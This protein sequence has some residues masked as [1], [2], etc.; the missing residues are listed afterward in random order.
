VICCSS[1]ADP[2]ARFAECGWDQMAP[3]MM[4]TISLF[5]F[6][7]HSKMSPKNSRIGSALVNAILASLFLV[8]L[9]KNACAYDPG[10]YAQGIIQ[11]DDYNKLVF[12][13]F[14]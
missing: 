12:T 13:S 5:P 2:A 14:M 11:N 9:S 7:T 8:L 10:N 4:L 3:A 6:S 1:I